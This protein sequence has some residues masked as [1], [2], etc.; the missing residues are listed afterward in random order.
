MLPPHG[1]W[2]T[3]ARFCAAAILDSEKAKRMASGRPAEMSA[4]HNGPL[5]FAERST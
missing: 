2:V 4:Y 5:Y 1:V 3:E